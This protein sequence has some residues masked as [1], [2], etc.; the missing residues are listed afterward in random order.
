MPV[1]PRK[2]VDKDTGADTSD[3]L[4]KNNNMHKNTPSAHTAKSNT[5]SAATGTMN[6]EELA[7][8]VN[9]KF[10]SV[11]ACYER[12]LKVNSALQGIVDLRITVLPSGKVA[13]VY[14][15]SDSVGDSQMLK[16]VKSTVKKWR[17]PK[18]EGGKII[19]DKP[20]NFK[21]KS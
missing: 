12:R 20:F 5:V 2:A 6:P 17:F 9:S 11:R 7:G 15:N 16:C 1:K 10:A 3:T 14:V 18:P 21:K 8:F 19:F 4:I 13:G